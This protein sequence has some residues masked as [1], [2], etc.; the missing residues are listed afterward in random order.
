MAQSLILVTGMSV[1]FFVMA[2]GHKKNA[3]DILSAKLDSTAESIAAELRSNQAPNV[4]ISDEY[5]VFIVNAGDGAIVIDH[6]IN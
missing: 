3:L 1:M 4:P 5:G 2:V 6:R